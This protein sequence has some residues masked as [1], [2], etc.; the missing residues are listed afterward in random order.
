LTALEALRDVAHV[1]AGQRVLI[2]G[3]SGGVGTFAVQIAKHLG[4][5]VTAVCT[6]TKVDMVRSI[7]ADEVFDYTRDDFVR[8]ERGYDV[9]F[10]NVGDRPWS[11]TRRVLTDEGMNVTIT[12]PKYPLAGP[13]FRLIV[14]KLASSFSAQRFTWFTARAKT[15]DLELM[16]G[17]L[18]AGE[19]TPVIE[20]T[21][22][23][24]KTADALRYLGE[25]HALGKIVI[26]P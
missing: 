7:G 9:L 12:G 5:R 1:E 26:V 20:N 8:T 4:A 19:V 17:L 16:A 15:E 14:R 22:A 23:L 24:E 3:A 2:N 25:G 10:D 21:Y 11:Q 18:A 6:T 13:F